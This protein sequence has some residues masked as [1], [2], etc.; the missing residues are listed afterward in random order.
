MSVSFDVFRDTTSMDSNF[1][2]ECVLH[3]VSHY[4]YL[5]GIFVFDVECVHSTRLATAFG[6]L[7]D[8]LCGVAVVSNCFCV[9]VRLKLLQLFR[10]ARLRLKQCVCCHASSTSIGS[11]T[12]NH[13]SQSG[14]T[15]TLSTWVTQDQTL[16]A[17]RNLQSERACTWRTKCQR[18]RGVQEDLEAASEVIETGN[19]P[20]TRGRDIGIS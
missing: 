2:N 15:W 3:V 12:C 16:E 6:C 14:C 4:V 8:L 10:I 20:T 11:T 17:T 19:G 5:F 7:N 18:G 13:E 1:S 9:Y